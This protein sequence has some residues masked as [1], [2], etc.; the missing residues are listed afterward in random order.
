M[1]RLGTSLLPRAR[2]LY[3]LSRGPFLALR[4]VPSLPSL[5]SSCCGSIEP[6][7]RLREARTAENHPDFHRSV[8]RPTATRGAATPGDS[9]LICEVE[10]A[11][12]SLITLRNRC[13]SLLR[14]ESTK[15]RVE[16]ARTSYKRPLRPTVWKSGKSKELGL[17]V[18]RNVPVDPTSAVSLVGSVRNAFPLLWSLRCD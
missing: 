3:P 8:L 5:I 4:L 2:D 10:S 18:S 16:R 14:V 1:R 15:N 9:P 7:T 11:F 12:L 6:R 17:F 13:S